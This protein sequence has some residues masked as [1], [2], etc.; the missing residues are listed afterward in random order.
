MGILHG[1]KSPSAW[2][3]FWSHCSLPRS[4][5]PKIFHSARI[6][7]FWLSPQVARR[8]FL[9][10]P[11]DENADT[12]KVKQTRLIQRPKVAKGLLP[13]Q[14]PDCSLHSLQVCNLLNICTV[15]EKL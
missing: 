9:I 8:Y 4:V 12:L 15:R 2:H 10:F 6:K 1:E 14:Y 5:S 11:N 7:S 13:S 3:M